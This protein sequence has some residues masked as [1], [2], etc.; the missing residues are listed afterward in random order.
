MRVGSLVKRTFGGIVFI[1]V[2]KGYSPR[3]PI[4]K[5]LWAGGRLIGEHKHYLEV[6]CE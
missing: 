3:N 1:G 6:V 2:V 4:V 5:V